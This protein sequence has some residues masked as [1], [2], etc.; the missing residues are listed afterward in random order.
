MGWVMSLL[1]QTEAD[2]AVHRHVGPLRVAM[3]AEQSNRNNGNN[4]DC[5][6]ALRNVCPNITLTAIWKSTGK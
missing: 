1:F 3:Q 6:M 5:S 2:L 4:Y